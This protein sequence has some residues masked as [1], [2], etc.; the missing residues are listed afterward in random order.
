MAVGIGAGGFVGIAVEGTS[1]TYEAPT[2][3]FP[4]RNE[5]LKWT[6]ENNV[7]KEIRGVADSIGIVLGN[8]HI[9]G[10]LEMVVMADVL[11][12]FLKASR[13]SVVKTGVGPY[14]YT[15]T[16]L[17]SAIAANTLSI[18]VVRNGVAFGYVGVAVSTIEF[19]QDN[20]LAVVK[21][22]MLG[23][24]EADQTL[25]TYS[26]TNQAP[27]G[28]GKWNIQIPT[29]TQVFDVDNFTWTVED[30]G[31][32]QTRLKNSLGAHFIKWG[33]RDVKIHVDRDFQD[34]TEMDAFKALT[35][36]T[37]SIIMSNDASNNQVTLKAF[38]AIRDTYDLNGL[39]G[40][41]DLIRAGIDWLGVYS[42]SDTKSYEIVVKTTENI[43]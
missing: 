28:A 33:E 40:Q 23:N 20:G 11:P 36:S 26:A 35:S 34:R 15:T 3:F 17:H 37:L 30:N 32:V 21:F 39:T 2:K 1:G 38:A 9:E 31:E 25:P 7:R 8:G 16:P 14:T 42:Q 18:T 22:S 19:S 43:T 13:N 24:S 29:A 5:S 27:F 41:G 6:Q 4:I 10:D 12:Y